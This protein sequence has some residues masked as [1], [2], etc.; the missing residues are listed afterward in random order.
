[1]EACRPAALTTLSL[2][3]SAA[4][5]CAVRGASSAAGPAEQAAIEI[6]RTLYEQR[7]ANCHGQPGETSTL[8]PPLAGVIGRRAGSV[9]GFAYSRRFAGSEHVWSRESLDAWLAS[10]TI[11]TP[12]LA[13]RHLGVADAFERQMLLA[14]LASPRP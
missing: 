2:V 11:A 13:A 10:V 4:L 5:L 14:F 9:P 8:A 7:C 1:M 6:G 12:D 3:L